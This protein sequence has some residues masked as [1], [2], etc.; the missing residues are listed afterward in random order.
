MK[1]YE[2]LPQK[3]RE[4]LGSRVENK[5]YSQEDLKRL[6]LSIEEEWI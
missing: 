6:L 2:I 3:D 5:D 4:L 1:L